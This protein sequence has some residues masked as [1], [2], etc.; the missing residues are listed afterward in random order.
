MIL[1]GFLLFP[2]PEL[3]VPVL[4]DVDGRVALLLASGKHAFHHYEAAV[5]R[6]IVV[7]G[8]SI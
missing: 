2:I 3:F 6:D 8:R 4:G 1:A 5:G 7:P